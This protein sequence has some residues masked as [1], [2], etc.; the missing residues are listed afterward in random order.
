MW[1]KHASSP[2]VFLPHLIRFAQKGFKLSEFED[3]KLVQVNYTN[4]PDSVSFIGYVSLCDIDFT[5]VKNYSF[6]NSFSLPVSVLDGKYLFFG[7]YFF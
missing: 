2:E 4:L 1:F 3:F 7:T 5:W 6:E